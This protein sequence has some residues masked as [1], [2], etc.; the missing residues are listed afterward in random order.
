MSAVAATV[1]GEAVTEFDPEGE[2][3]A[4][5]L[6]HLGETTAETEPAA[7]S[8]AASKQQTYFGDSVV[9]GIAEG[10]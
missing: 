8:G 2:I 1:A 10:M 6:G 7:P 4:G 3:E 9:A 5:F